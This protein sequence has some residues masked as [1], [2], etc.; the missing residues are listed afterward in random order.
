MTTDPVELAANT[1]MVDSIELMA[2]AEHFEITAP[3]EFEASGELLRE[4]KMKQKEVN[5]TRTAITDP[6]N[7]AKK[8]VMDLFKPV[9][10]RLSAA[11]RTIKAAMSDF[12]HAEVQR[13]REAQ[14]ELDKA[15]KVER[16][17]L[18][19][20]AARA[21]EKGDEAKAEVL[22]ESAAGTYAPAAPEPTKAAGVHTR[23]TWRAEV[24]DKAKLIAAAAADPA[25]RG[26]LQPNMPGLNAMARGFQE[27]LDIPGV[28]AVSEET[29]SA[30]A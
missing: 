29:V 4:I 19:R 10:E 27:K 6:M 1:A 2:Q 16:E 18:E 28:R 24:F 30:R 21:A 13:Q 8:R 9:T 15:A 26:F 14:L 20:R 12:T 25:F 11:E 3:T 17:R 22:E 23:T 5:D 7:A